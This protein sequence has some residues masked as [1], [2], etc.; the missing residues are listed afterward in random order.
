MREW[1]SGLRWRRFPPNELSPRRWLTVGWRTGCREPEALDQRV[2][3]CLAKAPEA[4]PQNLKR[5]IEILQGIQGA[6]EWGQPEARAW[7]AAHAARTSDDAE[8]GGRANP[9]ADALNIDPRR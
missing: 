8:E 3:D 9:T 7:W 2:V 5:I 1:P 6:G 4:R